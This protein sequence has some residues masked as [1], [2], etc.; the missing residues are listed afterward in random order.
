MYPAKSSIFAHK[1]H[2]IAMAKHYLLFASLDYAYPILRPLE[3][4]IVRRGGEAAWFVEDT[5]NNLPGKDE[6]LLRTIEEVKQFNPIAIFAPGNY[7]YDFFPGVKVEVFH[8]YPINK[9]NDKHD[10]HFEIRNWFDIYCTQGP[11]S[12]TTFKQIAAKRKFFKVYETGWCKTDPLFAKPQP[13]HTEHKEKTILYAA[14]FTKGISSAWELKDTI[15]RLASE[16]PW[17][18]ILTLH[19]K[20][21]DTR[22]LDDFAGIAS[23]HDNVEFRRTIDFVETFGESDAMLCDTSSIIVEYMLTDKPV[24]TYRNTNPGKHLL[25][26][27]DKAGIAAAIEHALTRPE[28]LMREIRKYTAQHEA[29][30]DGRNSARVLDAVDD[31]VNNYKGTLPN[32]PLNLLRKLKLRWRLKKIIL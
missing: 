11:S 4:E 26:V 1:A 12:T 19:P 24:V 5:C 32:K 27:T 31:F 30:R 28:S 18:W 20:I 6:K 17:R 7:I 21:T 22:L 2:H 13:R 29:H 3:A 14:T 16:K 23:R 8:G 15:D 25:N 10:N 9:R